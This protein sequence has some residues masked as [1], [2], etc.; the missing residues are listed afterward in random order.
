MHDER[1]GVGQVYHLFRL[2]E[3]FEQAVHRILHRLEIARQVQQLVTSRKAALQFLRSGNGVAVN[4]AI[5]RPPKGVVT[6]RFAGKRTT[7]L[8]SGESR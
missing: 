2:P 3:D 7:S 5:G 6:D 1:I 4:N 8:R